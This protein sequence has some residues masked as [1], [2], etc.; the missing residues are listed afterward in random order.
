M[1]LCRLRHT[2]GS[3]AHLKWLVSSLKESATLAWPLLPL[4][5]RKPARGQDDVLG[6]GDVEAAVAL[7][8]N[9]PG[10]VGE[11][12][13][14]SAVAQVVPTRVRQQPV[15]R[16]QAQHTSVPTNGHAMQRE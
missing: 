16:T 5:P 11:R 1:Q 6:E 2:V 15:T 3:A 4:P 13:V 8:S 9:R 12:D 10:V 7:D 14:C